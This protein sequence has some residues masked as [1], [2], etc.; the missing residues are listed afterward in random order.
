M[1]RIDKII[2]RLIELL[3]GSRADELEKEMNGM[4]GVD[5]QKAREVWMD[6]RL[7]SYLASAAVATITMVLTKLLD[8]WLPKEA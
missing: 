4:G 2:H 8:R 5:R 3:T 6:E 1:N 7:K